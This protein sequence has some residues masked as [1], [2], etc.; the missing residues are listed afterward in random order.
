MEGC[1]A[2][3]VPATNDPRTETPSNCLICLVVDMWLAASPARSGGSSVTAATL[4][5]SLSRPYPAPK[6]VNGTTTN[7]TAAASAKAR[8]TG[9]S[10]IPALTCALCAV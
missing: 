3:W 4:I 5:G 10:A 8:A 7:H 1:K 6:I 9:P 2:L